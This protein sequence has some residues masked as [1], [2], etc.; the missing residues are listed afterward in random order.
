MSFISS[1]F[2]SPIDASTNE[3]I[4]NTIKRVLDTFTPLYIKYYGIQMV[5]K[6]LEEARAVP[7]P[8][9]HLSTRPPGD[10]KFME[11][12]VL[13]RAGA[14]KKSM[15]KRYF[16]VRP[17]YMID[18]YV[19]EEEAKKEGGKKKGTIALCGY[20]VNEDANSG[21]LKRL[22]ALAEKMGIDTSSLPKPAEF[23]PQTMELYHSRRKSY[24][25]QLENKEDF[26]AWVGQMRTCCWMVRGFKNKDSCHMAAFTEAVRQTRWKLGR[27]G[28]WGGA[29]TEEEILSD[30]IADE[31]EW[32]IMGRIYS[33]IQGPWQVRQTV[34][35]KV[36]GVIDK[37]VLAAVT[38]AWKAMSTAVETARPKL[39]P[40]IKE[41][42]GPI[43]ELQLKI[44]D[45]IKE[46]SLSIINPNMDQHVVPHLTKI[47]DI[48]RKPMTDSY[49]SSYQFF[50]TTVIAKFEG[51]DDESHLKSQFRQLDYYPWSWHMWEITRK[52]DEMYDLLWALNVIFPDIWPWSLIWHA[53]DNLKKMMD[54]AVYTFEERIMKAREAGPIADM[55]ALVETTKQSVLA[56]YKHDGALKTVHYFRHILKSIVMPPLNKVLHPLVENILKPIQDAIPDA[57]KEL[58]DVV[59]MFEQIINNIIDGAIDNVLG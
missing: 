32:D 52:C 42:T 58:V 13:K 8:D 59:E 41:G 21:I 24:Y 47:I 12:W 31:L 17:D 10:V 45:Q 16:V 35:S 2:S 3:D 28:W 55:A 26:T 11:G 51:K 38:P 9:W 40:T 7:G 1:M 49:D 46:G 57:F 56:D 33:K 22:T 19:S 25:I 14:L 20:W 44:M 18:Y 29:G 34:R 27:W 30:M 37:T 5:K 54:N 23:A 15:Q 50:E 53:H 4:K 39:E 6:A 43:G 48:I 36:L